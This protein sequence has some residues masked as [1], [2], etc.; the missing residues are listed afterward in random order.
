MVRGALLTARGESSQGTTLAS[1]LLCR[2]LRAP[3]TFKLSPDREVRW[4]VGH[5]DASVVICQRRLGDG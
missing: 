4:I 1:S 5:M 2:E 3:P